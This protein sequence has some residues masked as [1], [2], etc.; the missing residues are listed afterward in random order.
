MQLRR[1]LTLTA[2]ALVAVGTVAAPALACGGGYGHFVRP[3]PVADARAQGQAGLDALMAQHRGLIDKVLAGGEAGLTAGE[4]VEWVRASGV[5][6]QVAKQRDAYATGLFW[7]DDLDEAKR[8]S[9]RSGK[10]ILSLRMLGKLTDER[11]CANSRFFRTLLYPDVRVAKL[12][13]DSFVLHWSSERA[14]PQVTIDFG[15][16]RKLETTITGNSIH[17]VLDSAGR[18]IEALPG[19]YAPKVFR[20]TLERTLGLHAAL[21]ARPDAQVKTLREYHRAR[22]QQL[23]SKLEADMRRA[24]VTLASAKGGP[25]VA[26]PMVPPAARAVPIAVGKSAVEAPMLPTPTPKIIIAGAGQL[27]EGQ[28]TRIAARWRQDARLDARSRAVVRNKSGSGAS[29][30]QA[31][32]RRIATIEQLLAEDTARNELDLHRKIHGWFGAGAK[33][34]A[35]FVKLNERVYSELFL[36][37]KSDPWLGL[38]NPDLYAALDADGVVNP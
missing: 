37:P 13:R 2:F 33:V 28:W 22:A 29:G 25:S 23:G 9:T 14:V 16:G 36:T 6:D 7:Y 24:G 3:D 4:R 11:S 35:D 27:T 15:D 34:V 31:V 20:E 5:I 21:K 26:M 38:V 12:L 8:V 19:L 1:A 32:A 10:P 18:P 30:R 17:Y